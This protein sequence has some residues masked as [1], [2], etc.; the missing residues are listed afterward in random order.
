MM[1]DRKISLNA[2]AEKGYVEL[3]DNRQ[4]K[5]SRLVQVTDAGR[6]L[7]PEIRARELPVFTNLAGEFSRDELATAVRVLRQ[8]REFL[9]GD[10]QEQLRT[11]EMWD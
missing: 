11:T 3:I 1:A 4:H 2:L 7:I 8:A 5:R 9:E 6:A 10:W